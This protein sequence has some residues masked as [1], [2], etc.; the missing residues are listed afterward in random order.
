M[1]FFRC[2]P[3]AAAFLMVSFLGLS[4]P[5]L[6]L[7][8]AVHLTDEATGVGG[9]RFAA[10]LSE[11]ADQNSDGRHEFLLGAP[12]D[13]INGLNAGA[14]FYYRS[15]ETNSHGLQKVWRG[16][17]GEQ[18]GYAVA[19]I[20]DVNDDGR[21]DFAVGAPYSDAGGADA[22]RVYIFF[23]ATTISNSAD[24]TITGSASGDLFGSAISAAGDFNGD[25]KDDFIVGAPYKN[26]PG[27]D[28]GAAFVIYGGNSGP[29]NN[30]ANALMLSGEIAGD[31]FGYSVTDA[32][33]FLGSAQD[34]VAVGAPGNTV[35][36]LDAGAAY[37]FEGAQAPTSPDAVFDLKIRNSASARPGSQYGFAV[38]GIGR[39]DSDSYDDLAIGAPYCNESASA[40]GRVEI[41]FGDPSPSAT[42]D[43]Y[44]NGEASSDHLGYSL[45][46]VGDV[47]GSSLDDLLI[48][49]PGHDSTASNA[50]RAY[51]YT[52]GSG[53]TADAGDLMVL[54]VAPLMAGT[55]A[56]DEFGW[57]VASAGLFDDDDIPDYAVGAP[58]GNIGST[59][60]A[61]Y[62]WVADSG[63]QVVATMLRSWQ[64]DWLTDGGV[65]LV[66]AF[67]SEAAAT[68]TH[69]ELVRRVDGAAAQTLWAGPPPRDSAGT[70]VLLMGDG[71][72]FVDRTAPAG[73]VLDYSLVLTRSD[74]STT[75]LAALAGP[76]PSA[77]PGALAAIEAPWPNPFNPAV[78]VRFLVPAGQQGQLRVMDVRGRQVARLFSGPGQ[79]GWRS[80]TW[81]GL[82]EAGRPAPSGVYVFRLETGDGVL[83]RRAVLAK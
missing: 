35:D 26:A 46:R 53:N 39:W 55:S 79:G 24:L 63:G 70:G 20:G 5:G 8:A 27:I 81:S 47:E 60:A 42:G 67:S 71:F 38:R 10:A 75:T 11:L 80:V 33:N 15:R 12:Q 18:F 17:P 49:A 40:A 69:L 6:P 72:T 4:L 73:A 1:Q 37:V 30:L 57:A 45:A 43:R 31:L 2:N 78:T 76:D 9:Q 19:R 54:D 56:G 59:A 51:I 28:S 74:G 58:G 25:G 21:E 65:R 41:V 61:G 82:T 32:G 36:G 23:G 83:T 34:C 64:A 29:S 62:C 7:K 22:G 77:V 50:G 16:A 44:V 68:M 13:D 52:G 48:G 3:R 66:F 14:V